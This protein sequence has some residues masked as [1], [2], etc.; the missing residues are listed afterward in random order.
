MD[1]NGQKVYSEFGPDGKWL[2][3]RTD[4]TIDQLPDLAKTA[5]QSKYS[6]MEI[7]AVQ[8]CEYDNVNP[9]YRVDFKQ[10]D[11]VKSVMVNDAGYV[12]E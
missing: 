9:F 4:M 6:G 3:T 12:S 10:G 1:N 2:R 5:I 11:Q 7:A 8:K